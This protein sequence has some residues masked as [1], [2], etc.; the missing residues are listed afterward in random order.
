MSFKFGLAGLVIPGQI[1]NIYFA[2]DTAKQTD[3]S[4]L[5]VDGI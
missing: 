5:I 3:P 4:C 2:L 1:K